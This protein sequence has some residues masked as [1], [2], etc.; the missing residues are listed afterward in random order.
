[1]V[2]LD[3]YE[4]VLCRDLDLVAWMQLH[5]LAPVDVAGSQTLLARMVENLIDNAVRHNQ[6]GGRIS[7]MCETDRDM[8]RLVVESSGPVLDHEA[9]AQLA[10]PF[11]RLGAERRFS[12]PDAQACLADSKNSKAL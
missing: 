9:V 5:A 11:N 4:V 12:D 7:V 8:A 6:P 1:M 10:E 3:D 2:T